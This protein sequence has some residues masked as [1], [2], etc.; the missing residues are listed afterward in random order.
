MELLT[1][2]YFILNIYNQI[3]ILDY[4]FKQEDVL[5]GHLALL[6]SYVNLDFITGKVSPKS[7]LIPL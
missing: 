4:D 5:P 7:I 2:I 6:Q 1:L 3:F